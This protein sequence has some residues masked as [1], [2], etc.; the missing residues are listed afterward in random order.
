MG[1][2]K[3]V[4]E[5]FASGPPFFKQTTVSDQNVLVYPPFI[6]IISILYMYLGI[7]WIE[8]TAAMELMQWDF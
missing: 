3:T 5:I 1:M 6:N 7:N 8:A 2:G 4:L